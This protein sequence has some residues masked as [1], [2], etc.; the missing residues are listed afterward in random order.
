MRLLTNIKGT[1]DMSVEP[2]RLTDRNR[3]VIS[4]GAIVSLIARTALECRD[5][6]PDDVLDNLVGRFRE[7]KGLD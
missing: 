3:N 7:D 2:V 5:D 6:L 1:K 4:P